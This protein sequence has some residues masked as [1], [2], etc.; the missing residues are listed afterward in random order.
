MPDAFHEAVSVARRIGVTVQVEGTLPGKGI[1]RDLTAQAAEQCVTNT[2]RHAEGD[3]LTVS[4]STEG[5]RY[6]ISFTNNGKAPEGPIRET[7]GLASLRRTVEAAGGTMTVQ[8]VPAF[9]LELELDVENPP[10]RG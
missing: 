7:G 1:V 9:R 4:V 6:R 8:S 5:T 2:A 3:L 10:I